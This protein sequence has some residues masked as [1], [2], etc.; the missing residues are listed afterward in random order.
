MVNG[1]DYNEPRANK[2]KRIGEET[3]IGIKDIKN[4][5]S[6]YQSQATH[7]GSSPNGSNTSTDN[8]NAYKQNR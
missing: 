7:C 1:F 2:I 5:A 8:Y 4:N 6:Q 3:E